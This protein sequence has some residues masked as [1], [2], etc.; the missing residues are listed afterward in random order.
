MDKTT[1]R[2][3][4][5]P[6]MLVTFSVLGG[7]LAMALTSITD[8]V[9]DLRLAGVSND[10]MQQLFLARSEAIKRNR[11][12]A[13]C[14][15]PD[16]ESCAEQGGWEQGWILFED[17]NNSGTR[18]AHEPILQRLNPLPP[19][20][21]LTANNPLARYVSYHPLGG[22]VMASGAFQ[23]GTFTLCRLSAGPGEGRQIIINAGGRPRVQKVQLES[24]M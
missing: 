8:M 22:T 17:T 24:C 18:E 1:Q 5:L 19:Q 21:R 20:Y 6:E 7:L 16:G 2:G 14:K 12:V 9:H 3:F 15:S 11:R 13:V 10:V 4:T 23:A